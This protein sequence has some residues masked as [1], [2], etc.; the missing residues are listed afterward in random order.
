[1]SLQQDNIPK[2]NIYKAGIVGAGLMGHGIAYS[3]AFS[4]IK[5]VLIDTS[6]A[7]VESALN[8]IKI[9]LTKDIESGIISKIEFQ[10]IIESITISDNYETLD[11]CDLII[12]A[13]YE[14]KELKDSII[15]NANKLLNTEGVIA[16]NTST[17]PISVLANSTNRPENFIGL[18]FFSPV[19]KMKLVE[20]IN[21]KLTSSK[22][23]SIA[24]DFVN[25]INKKPIVVNDGPGFF[26]TRVFQC[27]TNEGMALL[28]EGIKPED[29]EQIAKKAGYPIGP[30]A[31]LDEIS[32]NLAS[33]IRNQ[34]KKYSP[35][36]KELPY[37]PWDIVL[38]LMISKLNRTGRSGGK[39]FYEYPNNE[40]KHLWKGLSNHFPLS[41]STIK[42]VDIIDRF[43]FSQALETIRCLEEKIV[44]SF[45][46]ANTGSILGWGF[47][48]KTGGILSFVNNYGILAFKNRS[49][50]LKNNYGNRFKP[51]RLLVKMAKTSKSF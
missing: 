4:G 19:H 48:K 44:E 32:I 23:T 3:I 29:I 16:S 2:K 6:M 13:V 17:I 33:H 35:I 30:L 8:K 9:I 28:N 51:P 20:I 37:N 22:T 39:G 5:T 10:K 26:T 47:P 40:G 50:Y 38:N 25:F 46:D 27:Y 36:K 1:M 34:I 49:E 15:S 24:I 18:H 45:D 14:D 31:I 12:E 21:G 7:K 43:Y 11:R 41:N 42:E